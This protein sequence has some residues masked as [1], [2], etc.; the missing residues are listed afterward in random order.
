MVTKTDYEL[1]GGLKDY[2]PKDSL[3]TS[4]EE[5]K[6][7]QDT[8]QLQDRDVLSLRNLRNYV[9]LCYLEKAH[10]YEDRFCKEAMDLSQAMYSITAVIDDAIWR[11]GA[12]V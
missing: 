7:I 1:L 11:A 9:M 4:G 5:M 6:L 8:L 12:E 3:F 10:R 2:T